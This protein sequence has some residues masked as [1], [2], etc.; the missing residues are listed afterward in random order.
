MRKKKCRGDENEKRNIRRRKKN[1]H[2]ERNVEMGG[3]EVRGDMKR[4]EK[5]IF[6]P[7]TVPRRS[8]SQKLRTVRRIR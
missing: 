4:N 2:T 7:E 6:R 3:V 5:T 8:R 1:T